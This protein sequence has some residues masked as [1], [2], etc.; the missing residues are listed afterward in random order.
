MLNGEVPIRSQV[1]GLP[2]I[3]TDG[4][5]IA[6]TIL[7]D[8]GVLVNGQ[9][10]TASIHGHLTEIWEHEGLNYPFTALIPT[11]GKNGDLPVFTNYPVNIITG[12][13]GTKFGISPD[14]RPLDVR[15][16]GSVFFDR[17]GVERLRLSR[18]AL[19]RII[20]NN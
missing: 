17:S 2:T 9:K 15:T 7:T 1:G 18:K 4:D 6:Q 20:N 12:K 14:K 8:A 3:D 11:P 10:M 19:Q 16:L 5:A 13:F